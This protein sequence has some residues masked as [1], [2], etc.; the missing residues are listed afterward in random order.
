MFVSDRLRHQAAR[1]QVLGAVRWTRTMVTVTLAAVLV[2]LG[3][4]LPLQSATA[5]TYGGA[6]AA[7]WPAAWSPYT[8]ANG[9]SISDLNGDMSPPYLDLASGACA[10]CVGPDSSVELTSDGTNAFFRMRMAVDNNDS[11][12]GGLFGGAYLV[13]IADVNGVVKAVVGV[14]GTSTSADYVYAADAV[15]GA[16]TKV[17]EH[18]FT[19]GTPSSAGMR[20]I[21]TADGTGQYYLDFQVPLSVLQTVSGNAVT[22]STPVKLYYG[23]SAASNLATINKDFMLESAT[24]VS[25]TNLAVVKFVP[26]VYTVAFD[27]N[28]GSAVTSGSVI[29]GSPA[30]PPT[31]PTRSGYTFDGWYTAATGGTAW[32]FSTAITGDTTLYAHWTRITNQLTFDSNGGSAVEAQA[33]AEG[34]VASPPTAP[35]RTGYTFDGWHTA[36]TGGTAYDFATPVTGATTVHA[37]WIKNSYTVTFDSHGGSEVGDQTVAFD[38]LVAQPEDPTLS[39]YVFAGWYTTAVGG[40][41]WDFAA[42]PVA[43]NTTLHARWAASSNVVSF[44][45]N[46]GTTVDAQ[47]VPYEDPATEP[48]DPTRTGYTFAGWYDG[49]TLHDFATPITG[50]TTLK[51]SWTKNTYTVSFD[52]NGGTTVDAQTVPYEDPAT[53]PTTPTRTGY[54]FDGWYDAAE[55]GTA[56]DFTTPVT[57][58]LVLYG[59]WTAVAAPPAED[60][61]GDGLSDE[62]EA[63]LGTN[64]KKPDTDGD[65]IRD[66]D[67]VSGSLNRF[68]NCATDPLTK[69]TDRDS[70]SDG[71]EIR[72]VRLRG[73]LVLPRDE[74]VR[75]GRVKPDPCQA[76]TD[77][78]GLRDDRE[79]RGSHTKKLGKTYQSNP[80]RGDTD[81]DGLKDRTEV[82]GSA[83]G[84]YRHKPTDPM[85]WDTD[86]GGVSDGFEVRAGSDPTDNRSAPPRQNLRELNLW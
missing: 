41:E 8:F 29:E 72:G 77:G 83:N 46:G 45:A 65:G 20:W 18:P 2:V 44:D 81:R 70:L 32:S 22:P 27:S 3:L 68:G 13:Q 66:G 56:Y 10:G 26:P 61:D 43:G 80:L 69:D 4:T 67:E 42:D 38:D 21:S 63:E 76:D 64:P 75:P 25:F 30:T 55:G 86:E 5:V 17:Y 48:T 28:G 31:A 19:G 14:D 16:L 74:V 47:T 53:E 84:K 23:S 54:T 79:V 52:A 33:V 71:Q 78:D 36:A 1:G 73:P 85:N 34:D 35:T 24:S 11:G 40:T 12:K 6:S 82:T 49:D 9:T 58:A 15:G 51:A 7:D 37:H 57:G 60:A 59:H 50:A 39:E 62:D